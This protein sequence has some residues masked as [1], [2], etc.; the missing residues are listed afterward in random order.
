[1][2]TDYRGTTG[3]LI[4]TG[5][6]PSSSVGL[7][8]SAGTLVSYEPTSSNVHKFYISEG[9]TGSWE[10]KVANYAYEPLYSSTTVNGGGYFNINGTQTLELFNAE[11]SRSVVDS[12][13]ELE[14]LSKLHDTIYSFQTTPTGLKHI[15][16]LEEVGTTLD[17]M[18][19]NLIVNASASFV[20]SAST[21][22]ITIKA[23]YLNTSSLF[24]KIT[25]TGTI[26]AISGAF[27]NTL[28]TDA[29]SS[30][31]PVE[32]TGLIVG[33]R[34]QLYNVTDAVVMDNVVVTG[35]TY[36][37][38]FTYTSNKT[39]RLR[40]VN[41]IGTTAYNNIETTGVFSSIG[42]TF[43]VSPTSDTVYNNIGLDG[44][45]V[46][47]FSADYPNVQVDINDGDGVTTI[48]RMYS[49]Y[50]YNEMSSSGVANFFDGLM[51]DDSANF[52][53]DVS[54]INLLLD[55]VGAIPVMVGGGRIYRSD[56]TTVIEATSNSI[57]LDPAKA[58]IASS[59]LIE[60]DLTAI[61]NNA[62]LIPAL[63]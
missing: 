30:F 37:K 33:S 17:L 24:S 44:S 55:S 53:I 61:K 62:N 58:Y 14:T 39:L 28:Y 63:L 34:I 21:D 19:H 56:G 22:T 27:M 38:L 41:V 20:F 48:Q 40:V 23:P 2:V 25:T 9:A 60:N 51:A 57:Q 5:I 26:N 4:I 18:G 12:Y 42:A 8:N 59:Q 3:L 35:T 54:I 47:E 52:K 29:S 10:Y 13:T 45:T 16:M 32:V 15:P 46:T 36:Y 6:Q 1:V 7:Y 49:W 31:V 11:P 43:L 50:R